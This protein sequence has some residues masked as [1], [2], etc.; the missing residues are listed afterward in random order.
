[1]RLKKGD[2]YDT[3]TSAGSYLHIYAKLSGASKTQE[4]FA[5]YVLGD[6]WR[7]GLWRNPSHTGAE[8]AKLMLISQA[9]GQ[10]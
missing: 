4:L 3:M 6:C 8:G 10:S 5:G 2:R 7:T 9:K 1:M